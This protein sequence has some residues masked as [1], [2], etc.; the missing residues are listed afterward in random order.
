MKK[1]RWR[2]LLKWSGRIVLG[3]ATLVAVAGLG[4]W[5]AFEIWL[6]ASLPKLSGR[7]EIKG[8]TAPVTILRDRNAVPHIYAATLDDAA[9]ALGFV[10]AQD[11]LFQMEAQRRIGAG[12]MSELAGGASVRFDRLMRVLGLYR[13]AQ[14]SERHLG[15]EAKRRLAAYTAGVN[16]YLAQRRED[17]P[18]EFL[19]AGTP[20]PWTPADSLVW[21]KLMALGLSTGWRQELTRLQ[22]VQKLGAERAE[23][24][25]PP[26]PED[27]PTTVKRDR[28]AL[29]HDFGGDALWAMLPGALRDGGASNQW[30]ASGA[31]TA[32]GKPLLANDPHLSL[33]APS[34]WYLVRIETPELTLAGATVPGVPAV[35]IG[36]NR[37]IA[38][39]LTTPHLDAEDLF[40]EKLDPTDPSKYL[41]PEGP[42]A[43]TTR[44]ETIRVRFGR[45]VTFTVRETRHGPVLDDAMDPKQMPKLE[46]GQVLALR[47]AW[48]EPGDRTAEAMLG[49]NQ[50]LNW[51]QFRA[52]LALYIAPAQNFV[53]ADIDGNI[54]YYLPGRIPI[55]KAGDGS[56]PLPG[57]SSD[58]GWTGYVPF[59]RLPQLYNP[60][61]GLIVNAN[62]R[63]VGREYPFFLSRSW[64]DHYRAARI[65]A[66]LTGTNT[67]GWEDFARI[68]GDHVSLMARD[69][70]PLLLAVPALSERG[71][72]AQAQLRGWTAAMQRD[73]PE[74]LLFTAW[75][76]QLSRRIF[77]SVLGDDAAEHYALAPEIVHYVLTQKREACGDAKRPGRSCD[78]LVAKSLEAALDWIE[79]RHGKDLSK[80]RWGAEHFAELRHRIFPFVPLM[81]DFGTLRIA[82]DGDGR[83]VN[84]ADMR[85]RDRK[86]PFAARH[87]SGVRAIF[88]FDDLDRSRFIL[89][90]GPAG[91]P[92]SPYYGSM[93]A[94]WRDV[95][96]VT[97]APNRAEAE[98]GAAGIIELVPKP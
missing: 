72:A 5:A 60:A 41:T 57:W 83:T 52:A 27:G 84:R 88:T 40:I 58:N 9:F 23:L 47:A 63:V 65:E 11:R 48:L 66:L 86:A 37:R 73:R 42:K 19:L 89:S 76:A 21:G 17:L 7:Y 51:D 75:L 44:S 26:Y 15:P 45:D 22:L 6:P 3:V 85:I 70:L 64:G 16:A 14:D 36:H 77:D 82:K 94:D 97:L 29:P 24:F 53:Y 25:F 74:G 62:N 79:E 50:A 80:W 10:H 55:R 35:I 78:E 91:H 95:R 28:A 38:W 67:H 81:S 39:G 13:L 59:E 31:R 30:V 92:R 2:R 32:S 33:D 69:I 71:K 93:L 18:P 46:T 12:R 54:G 98:K 96:Y 8:I 34:L 56:V 90:T 49:I 43:F 20:E 1:R 87:G 68:Q 61:S 4:G